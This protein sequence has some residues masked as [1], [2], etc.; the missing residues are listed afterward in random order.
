MECF[1]PLCHVVLYITPLPFASVIYW[2][3]FKTPARS[4]FKENTHL[5]FILVPSSEI[6]LFIADF[7]VQSVVKCCVS[8]LGICVIKSL[9]GGGGIRSVQDS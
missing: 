6:M 8:E 7:V 1:L 2:V 9:G 5:S 4:G 3:V